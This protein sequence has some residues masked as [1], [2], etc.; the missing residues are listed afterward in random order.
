MLTVFNQ[1]ANLAA[2]VSAIAASVKAAAPEESALAQ[3]TVSLK[4]ASAALGK[5]SILAPNPF[6]STTATNLLPAVYDDVLTAMSGASPAAP[7]AASIASAPA[8]VVA[9]GVVPVTQ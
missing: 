7:V 6:L 8:K 9:A 1:I 5:A 4:I 3:R 2:G